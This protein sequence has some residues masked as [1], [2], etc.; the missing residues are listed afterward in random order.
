MVRACSEPGNSCQKAN[1][2]R[3]FTRH[4]INSAFIAP[5]QKLPLVPVQEHPDHATI[6]QFNIACRS[7]RSADPSR[8]ALCPAQRWV[9]D[10]LSGRAVRFEWPLKLRATVGNSGA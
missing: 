6:S 10:F 2:A 4:C 3:R 9:R 5:A 7:A 8:V 1:L